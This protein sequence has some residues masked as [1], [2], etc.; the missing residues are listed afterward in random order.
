M[1][2]LSVSDSL[3]LLPKFSAT[4]LKTTGKLGG[5]V[6]LRYLPLQRR[7]H[8]VVEKLM[9]TRGEVR[10]V[11]VKP[12]QIRSSTYFQSLIFQQMYQ[13]AGTQAL[14]LTHR[15]SVTDELFAT[16]KRFQDKLPDDVR[17][18]AKK[19]NEE[20][21]Y[22]E[23]ESKA[24]VA[25]AGSDAGRGFPCRI[26]QWSEAGRCTGRQVKD[27]QEGALQTLATGEG[28]IGAVESTSGGGQTFF[29]DLAE[30]GRNPKERWKTLFFAWHEEPEYRLDP[31]KDWQPDSD[32]QEMAKV[33]GWDIQQ[34][35]WRHSK[36]KSEFRG[37]TIA[38]NREYPAT[39]DMAFEAAGGRLINYTAILKAR[40]S[41]IIPLAGMPIIMGVDPAGSGDRTAI[42]I[43]QG[44]A[45]LKVLIFRKMDDATLTGI[46]NKLIN[47]WSVH[48][49]FIDMGYGHGTVSHLRD[50]GRFNVIGV[51]FGAN[52]TES[53]LYR[54]KRTEMAADARDWIHQGPNDEGGLVSIP[55]S[56]EFCDDLKAIP[57]FEF[58]G[59]KGVFYLA[60]KDKIKEELRKSTDCFDALCLTFAFPVKANSLIHSYSYMNPTQ[61]NSLLQT[62]NTFKELQ[63]DNQRDK[64]NPNFR[65]YTYG[66]E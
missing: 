36:L 16:L 56:D 5:I 43:R 25:T 51:H 38:F 58:S 21:L 54:N 20:V 62:E 39:F 45:V 65:Y 31:P 55:D 52:A 60:P 22:L 42:A 28:S 34:T 14:T 37:S 66:S 48:T 4:L 33:F 35:Y 49:C 9:E 23:N 47:E 10:M 15:N 26:L 2:N 24:K 46:V 17:I 11:I 12:R 29:H 50:M 32:E 53:H 61:Q 27:V 13:Y 59:S 64:I 40:K 18:P 44:N 7:I 19:D 63:A 3:I 1:S 41:Q 8:A 30:E 6:D 57:D